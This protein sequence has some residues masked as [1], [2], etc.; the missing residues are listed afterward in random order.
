MKP[1]ARHRDQLSAAP[2]PAPRAH[3][4]TDTRAPI[5][6]F[7]TN[8]QGSCSV[9]HQREADVRCRSA[10]LSFVSSDDDTHRSEAVE[11]PIVC[12]RPALVMGYKHAEQQDGREIAQFFADAALS[13]RIRSPLFFQRQAEVVELPTLDTLRALVFHI[14]NQDEGDKA[15]CQPDYWLMP[16]TSRRLARQVGPPIVRKRRKL[17]RVPAGTCC[18]RR[19]CC[20]SS[21]SH[22]SINANDVRGAIFTCTAVLT[23]KR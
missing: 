10:W 13:K 4:T 9:C 8:E 7:E 15:V 11:G 14:S 3:L 19:M 12:I 22:T 17:L 20:N 6:F 2:A 16:S 18:P 21:R 23:H 5:K 1:N